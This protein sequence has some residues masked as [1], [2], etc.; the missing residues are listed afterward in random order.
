MYKYIY[1]YMMHIHTCHAYITLHC[2]SF[3]LVCF[4]CFA[5]LYIRTCVPALRR[6]R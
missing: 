3:V 5:F 4:V 1:I 6:N 2:F